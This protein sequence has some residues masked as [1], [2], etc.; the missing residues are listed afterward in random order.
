MVAL[1]TMKNAH[2]ISIHIQLLT[3]YILEAVRMTVP[4]G[5]V[6]DCTASFQ[7]SIT[8]HQIE[9]Q[10]WKIPP[11]LWIVITNFVPTLILIPL[12][13]RILYVC[14]RFS[15]LKRITVGEVFLF[16]SI[17]VAIGVEVARQRLLWSDFNNKNSTIVINAI[18]F[19]TE[20]TTTLHIASPLSIFFVAPQYFLFAFAEI[21]CNI[22][23]E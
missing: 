12:V 3:T 19:H 13:D 1:L 11:S 10:L 9:C 18:P 23:G 22:T 14:F 5:T 17:A 8:T 6:D 21:F 2:C 16:L 4:Y 7:S 15:M 20:S